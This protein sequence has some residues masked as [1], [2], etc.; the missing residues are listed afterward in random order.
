MH[1]FSLQFLS[2]LFYF[3][4][5]H[6]SVAILLCL[7]LPSI[8]LHTHLPT[9]SVLAFCL[10]AFPS[11]PLPL[12]PSYGFWD[13]MRFPIPFYLP[14]CW[15]GCA[16]LLFCPNFAH[17]LPF[18]SRA[19][20]SLLDPNSSQHTTSTYYPSQPSSPCMPAITY[21]QGYYYYLLLF[22]TAV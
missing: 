13:P 9:L 4:A 10:F 3:C 20:F 17:T 19:C 2:S 12:S 14:T 11:M 6:A 8:P 21:L 22:V 1:A 15:M 7:F 5:C 18:V 16:C